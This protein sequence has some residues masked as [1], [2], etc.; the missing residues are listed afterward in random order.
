MGEM[1]PEKNTITEPLWYTCMCNGRSLC[2]MAEQSSGKN[3][4]NMEE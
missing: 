3:A 4:S 2:D 1:P